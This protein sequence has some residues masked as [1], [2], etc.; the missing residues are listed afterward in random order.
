VRCPA[1]LADGSGALAAAHAILERRR[2]VRRFPWAGE[3]G[4][5]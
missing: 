5:E 3:A 4:D 1:V 2:D